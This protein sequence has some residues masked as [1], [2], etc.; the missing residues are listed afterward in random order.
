[1][2]N[3]SSIIRI[4]PLNGT[5]TTGSAG[6]DSMYVVEL[7]ENGNL[8]ETRELPGKSKYYADDVSENWDTGII[9]LEGEHE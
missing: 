1:M 8:V 6:P 3:R 4:V 9:Q 7:Y 2:G 5:N